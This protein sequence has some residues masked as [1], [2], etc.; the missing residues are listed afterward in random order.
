LPL[1][2]AQHIMVA[3]SRLE[4]EVPDALGVRENVL[5]VV[6]R[7]EDAAD[8]VLRE[9]SDVK[10]VAVTKTVEP[11]RIVEAIEAGVTCIG[12]NRIQE[13]ERKFAEGLPPVEKHLVGHLQRNK[14]PRALELFDMIESVDSPRLAREISTRVERTE[15]GLPGLRDGRADVLIEV[16]TSGEESKYGFEPDEVV[17]AVGELADLRGIRILGLMTVGA[18]L[19]DPEDV[20][21]CFRRLRELRDAIEE[22]VIPGVSMD[23]LSMGMTNDFEVAIE[24]GSTMVRVGRAIFGER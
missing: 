11:E 14:V 23:H 17:E 7:I 18:F 19:P 12:E 15:G 1:S 6:H 13:A 2:E 21:P 10:L 3:S 24:E 4:R 5:Q 22:A 8:R 20:R 9:P 16:N